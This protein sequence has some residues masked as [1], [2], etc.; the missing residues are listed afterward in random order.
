MYS[1]R[2]IKKS[3]LLIYL[4]GLLQFQGF[5]GP[6]LFVFYTSYMGLSTSEYLMADSVLFFIMAICEV[7]SGMIADFFGR[8]KILIVSK[9]MIIVGMVLLITIKSFLG[10]IIVAIIYGIFGA[11]ESGIAESV[12]YEIFSKNQKLDDYE[13]TT[14]RSNSV[15]FFVSVIYALSSGYLIELNLVLPVVCDLIISIITLIVIILLLE[16]HRNYENVH[17]FNIRTL[18]K[19]P[20]KDILK[21]VILIIIIAALL[22]CFSRTIFSF[23]QPILIS[24]EIPK[25]LLG[26]AAA[27]YSIVAG[28][29][30]VF[31]KKIRDTVN[32]KQMMLLVIFLQI[33]SSLGIFVL[34]SY[35]FIVFIFI[36]QI[37]R[38]IMSPFLYMQVNGH[39]P[40][41]NEN[42]VTTM[43]IYYFMT[44]I[45]TSVFLFITS[46][47]T[48]YANIKASIVSFCVTIN[49]L[50]LILVHVYNKK[51]HNRSIIYYQKEEVK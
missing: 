23:Y 25:F 14:A 40:E 43:S 34:E 36:Q 12:I 22:S 44:T 29:S 1:T 2:T 31:Y 27:L 20:E 10:A 16:D 51:I 3:K 18:F 24:L 39:I 17:N 37:Q 42:R 13:F 19:L 26:Y 11:M 49:I 6:V 38:G 32:R 48:Q 4:C 28:I 41:D 50:I 30:L 15:G 35:I 7:P 45:L 9:I 21:N 8:K 46:A 47:I 33:I 5:I